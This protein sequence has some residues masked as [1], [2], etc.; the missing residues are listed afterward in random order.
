[1]FFKQLRL[2]VVI[3][4][5]E[6]ELR[7]GFLNSR[8]SLGERGLELFDVLFG[9]HEQRLLLIDDILVRPWIDTESLLSGN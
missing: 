3:L 7:F 5:R 4:L 6:F 1:M 2:A 8:R 9:F